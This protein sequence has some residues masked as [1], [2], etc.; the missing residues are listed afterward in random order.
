MLRMRAAK[1]LWHQHPDLVAQQLVPRVSEKP[2]GLRIDQRDV[3]I[4]VDDDHRIR[5][6]LEQ[7]AEFV[8]AAS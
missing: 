8:L 7:R 6:R 5:R 4:R 2:F 1:A 3:A